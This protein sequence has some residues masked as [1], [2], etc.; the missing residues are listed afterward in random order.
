[1]IVRSLR[2]FYDKLEERKG[3]VRNRWDLM[4]IARALSAETRRFPFDLP[5]IYARF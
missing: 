1:M 5:T 4:H 3:P 2:Y